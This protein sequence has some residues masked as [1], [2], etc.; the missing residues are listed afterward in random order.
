M[1]DTPDHARKPSSGPAGDPVSSRGAA[2]GAGGSPGQPPEFNIIRTAPSAGS[3]GGSPMPLVALIVLV[4]V[5]GAAFLLF[6]GGPA[7]QDKAPV[8]LSEVEE[9]P[10]PAWLIEQLDFREGENLAGALALAEENLAAYPS[11]ELRGRIKR[12]REELGLVDFERSQAE[13]LAEAR[14]AAKQSDWEQVV[15]LADA[16][17]AQGESAEGY[18]LRGVG[19]GEL[20][21]GL[22]A[23]NDL[24]SALDLGYKPEAEV[25][26]LIERFAE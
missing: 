12:Y 8:T 21:N 24:Q 15:E 17:L 1:S 6:R 20:G 4:A 25:K 9:V 13:L 16:A 18:F 14:A 5:G 22:A 19:N 2:R 3:G 10:P 7:E 23:Q 11:E 26:A